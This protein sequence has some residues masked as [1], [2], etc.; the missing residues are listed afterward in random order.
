MRRLDADLEF[1]G[2]TCD[3]AFDLPSF[4]SA[5][6]DLFYEYE[7]TVSVVRVLTDPT[8]PTT[9]AVRNSGLQL[10]N[11]SFREAV[12]WQETTSGVQEVGIVSNLTFT[13]ERYQTVARRFFWQG[14]GEDIQ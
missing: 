14:D 4:W 11:A 7:W 1:V 6:D 12:E 3:Q 10:C 13:D 9:Y 5:S 8:S 2:L